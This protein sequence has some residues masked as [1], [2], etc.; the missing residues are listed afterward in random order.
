MKL[1]PVTKLDKRN[2]ATS[3]KFDDDALSANDDV[4]VTFQFLANLEQSRSQP[5]DAWSA[6]I[7]K[8]KEVL[9]LEDIF[10][11]LAYVCT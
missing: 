1:G 8:I 6:D 5:Q 9:V 7:S 3:E 11:E 4:I 10:S 2:T